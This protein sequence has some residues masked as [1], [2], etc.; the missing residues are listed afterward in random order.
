MTHY[1]FITQQVDEYVQ[2]CVDTAADS[3]HGY[4]K[5]EAALRADGA[6]RIWMKLYFGL[7]IRDTPELAARFETDMV[8]LREMVSDIPTKD[9]Y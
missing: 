3:T 7:A 8:R 4:K 5:K 9:E 6:V 1:D 2:E